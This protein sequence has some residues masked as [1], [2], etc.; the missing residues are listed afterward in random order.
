MHKYNL[1]LKETL[2]YT[3]S[4]AIPGIIGL[5]SVI[6]FMRV[7]GSIQYGEYSLFISQ[8]NLIVAIVFGWL[9]QSQLRYYSSDKKNS[10]YNRSQFRSLFLCFGAS[11]IILSILIIMQSFSIQVW[12]ISLLTIIS[13]G[14]F[15]YI[16]TIYQAKLRPINIIYMTS[17]QS[18][19]GLLIPILLL[20]FGWTV[21]NTILLGVLLSFTIVVLFIGL[22]SQNKVFFEKNWSIKQNYNHLLIKKW[23][24]YGGP[25]SIWLA[26]GLALPFLDRFFINQYLSSSNLGVYS[27]LQEL[28]TRVYSLILFPIILALHPRIM[29]LWNSSNIYEATKLIKNGISIFLCFGII[30]IF[31][32]WN[33]FD[34]IFFILQKAI[35]ELGTHNKKLIIPLLSACF[36]WQLSFLTHKMLELKEKT[37]IMLLAIIPSLI[38]N[39]IG[40][41]LF[42]PR[43]GELATASTAFISALMYCTITFIYSIHNMIQIKNVK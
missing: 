14:I 4:K 12:L 30:I 17:V 42:L 10:E 25:I 11:L 24:N 34:S 41:S 32:V 33:F 43:F 8:C 20:F 28:L 21:G 26:V 6:L 36:L 27:G 22:F 31:I 38:V 19:L 23:F 2:F 7:F 29:N 35:P 18:F 16:K 40:N 3:V 15:N 37:L 1:L 9:N 13:I 5:V 39:I